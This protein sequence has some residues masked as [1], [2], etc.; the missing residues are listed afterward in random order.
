MS[1]PSFASPLFLL[2][3]VVVPAT[4]A[5]LVIV[6]RR[7]ARY[8]MAFTNLEL[9]ASVVETRRAWR[10]WV[11][12][13]LLLLALA[14]AATAV[15]R[16]RVHLTVP[17]ENATVVL[18]VDVSGS[19]RSNDVA[20]SRLDAA[21]GAMRRFIDRLPKKVKVGLV[22]FS[23]SADVLSQPTTD[24]ETVK[25]GL[26]YLTPEAATALSSG[27]DA[28]TRVIVKSLAANGVTHEQGSYLPAAIVLESDGSQ[29]RGTTTPVEAARH[30]KAAG[31][32]V[33][34]VALGTPGGTVE[35]DYGLQTTKV[36]VPP[37]PGTVRSIARITGGR[38]FTVQDSDRLNTVY[39]DLGSSIGRK[40]ERR[41]IT[42]W[43]AIAS[44][45]LLVGGVG[46]SRVWSAPL[47]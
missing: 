20:P 43:F 31:V 26:A 9:L 14:S 42:Q 11:P 21:V 5:F 33:Y 6:N 47:P 13:A 34:G 36:P 16:P 22:A 1:Q 32:R 28:A 39:R 18:L 25:N 38:A 44:A 46:V 17:Q 15:A 40:H 7:R 30:A 3:L 41:E 37:D 29:N 19:M 2:A 35:Y 12:V 8:P 4:L 23:S 10:R 27:I 24:R 45:V